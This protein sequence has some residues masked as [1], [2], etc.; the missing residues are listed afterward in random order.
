MHRRAT[1]L[2]AG[3]VFVA[4][5]FTSSRL[6]LDADLSRMI[7]DAD[8]RVGQAISVARALLER[9]TIE[10][11]VE[12][13]SDASVDQL[14][15]VADSIVR[16]LRELGVRECAVLDSESDTLRGVNALRD[17]AALVTDP[18]LLSDIESRLSK[19]AIERRLLW[20]ERALQE[21][22]GVGQ[23][24]ASDPLGISDGALVGLRDAASMFKFAR[25]VNGCI[26]IVGLWA[27]ISGEYISASTLFASATLINTWGKYSPD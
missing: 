17:R 11:A 21:P 16:D 24:A 1:I 15:A 3:T 20:L 19:D 9:L 27:F 5:V 14:A 7:P 10:I 22:E 23:R 12:D 13:G 25:I 4:L 8:P 18:A 2:V 26:I 6:R